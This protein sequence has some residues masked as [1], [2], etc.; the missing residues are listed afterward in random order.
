MAP[1]ALAFRY[2]LIFATPLTLVLVTRLPTLYLAQHHLK[3]GLRRILRKTRDTSHI[4]S[5]T[6]CKNSASPQVF[7]RRRESA[8]HQKKIWE[9]SLISSTSYLEI[10]ELDF[11]GSVI[12]TPAMREFG[13]WN[14]DDVDMASLFPEM[15]LYIGLCRFGV[16]CTHTHEPGCAKKEAVEAGDIAPRRYRSYLRIRQ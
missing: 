7:K 6:I 12:D 10:F 15:R 5:S 14:I 9:V 11:G 16:D 3:R 1:A 4:L 13:L 8:F 2:G